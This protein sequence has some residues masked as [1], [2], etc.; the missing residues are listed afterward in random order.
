MHDDLLETALV[1]TTESSHDFR[2]VE[3]EE[4]IGRLK[5]AKQSVIRKQISPFVRWE[6]L[7]RRPKFVEERDKRVAIGFFG[8]PDVNVIVD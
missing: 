3:G 5:A 4:Y 6:E 2:A 8:R 1:P 7:S